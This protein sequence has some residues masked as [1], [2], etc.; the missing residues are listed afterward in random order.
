MYRLRGFFF[1]ERG[2]GIGTYLNVHGYSILSGLGGLL[3][4][5]KCRTQATGLSYRLIAQLLPLSHRTPRD[6]FLSIQF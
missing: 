6:L 1:Q 5:Q 3:Y 4:R 2:L